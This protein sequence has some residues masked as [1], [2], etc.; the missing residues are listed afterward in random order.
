MNATATDVLERTVLALRPEPTDRL[1]SPYTISKNLYIALRH[2]LHDVGGQPDGP[3]PYVDYQ[4][5]D[6]EMRTYV[7]CEV[8][9][10]RGAWT[11][12]ERACY[13]VQNSS[14][15]ASRGVRRAGSL[16]Y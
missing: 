16:V 12:D 15:A 14:G 3:I 7:T 4:E 10:W 2:V 11:A 9:A 8:L 1:D 13:P 6:W 5:P